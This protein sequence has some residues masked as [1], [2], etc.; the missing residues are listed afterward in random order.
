MA[1]QQLK[2][3]HLYNTAQLEQLPC[4]STK[5]L[6]PLDEIVGQERAQKAVEFAMNI[7]EKG[8]NI[9]AIGH[10][11]LGKRTMILRYLNRHQ[12]DSSTLFDWC[13]VANFD[14]VRI[15]KVLKLPCGVGQRF[16]QDIETLMT[17]LV[18]AMPLAFD[19]EMYISRAER[20]KNQLAQKQQLELEKISKAAKEKGIS[21]TL[22]QQGDYQ[23]IAMD[24]EE[25]HT[26]ETFDALSLKEQEEFG[27]SIDEL[28]VTLRDMVRQLTDWEE[29]YSDKIKKLNDE[30]T[31]DVIAHFIKQ[32]KVD[33]ADYSEI[34]TFLTALQKDIVENAEIFLEE[35][36]EQGE[37]ATASLDKKLPRRYKVN[38]L[39]SRD[40]CEFPIVVEETQTIT[41]CLVTQKPRRSRNGIH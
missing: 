36:N 13:Y 19:N 39:V 9:Y 4:K 12:Y 30:V 29:N 31:L 16:R 3:E 18:K 11:G 38:V 24:G 21:L 28:E 37:I 41:V 10:N 26:E 1:I 23:F 14:D 8:Y 15:P 32:L 5:E 6:A 35:T 33:Y 2:A 40:G 22:T 25:L 17:K 7:K 20:L 27:T 34:K